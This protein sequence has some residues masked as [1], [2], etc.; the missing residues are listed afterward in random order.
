MKT[1]YREKKIKWSNEVATTKWN[2]KFNEK[3]VIVIE[4]KVEISQVESR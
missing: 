2:K 3:K 4:A 1:D